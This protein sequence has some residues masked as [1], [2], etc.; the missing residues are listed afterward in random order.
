MMASSV[1][2]SA[3]RSATRSIMSRAIGDGELAIDSPWQTGHLMR[4][5]I[6]STR[7]VALG[8]VTTRV[9]STTAR[10]AITPIVTRLRRRSDIDRL[11]VFDPRPFP[12]SRHHGEESPGRSGDPTYPQHPDHG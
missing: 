12:T 5:P 11:T 6:A 7:S 3:T 10:T 4:P 8:A 2:P 9:P 1:L